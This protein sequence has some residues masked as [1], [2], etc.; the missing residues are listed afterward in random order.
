MS[1]PFAHRMYPAMIREALQQRIPLD[2][3]DF[4]QLYTGELRSLSRIHW[5]PVEVA[6]RA[7]A[8]LAPEPGVR[9]LDIGSGVGKLC[10][11][12]ALASEASWHG[13]ELD[14][15]RVA[16][17]IKVAR[18]LRVDRRACFTCGEMTSLDWA[19]FDSLYLFNPFEAT[20]YPD[21]PHDR[22]VVFPRYVQ[23]VGETE[24]R[25]AGLPAGTRVVTYHGFGGE[26]PRCYEMAWRERIGTDQLVLWIKRPSGGLSR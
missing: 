25:L 12:G 4:D 23:H 22:C 2:D 21:E 26:V 7:V 19:D 18:A 17:A 14:A 5:T 9:V 8:L 10:C 11:I 15:W 6:L 20:L 24:D 3:D 13:V 16:T 1:H